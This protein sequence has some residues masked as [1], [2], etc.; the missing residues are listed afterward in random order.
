[1]SPHQFDNSPEK[2]VL[3]YRIDPYLSATSLTGATPEG[4]TFCK[5]ERKDNVATITYKKNK[6]TKEI[7]E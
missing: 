7:E 6:L 2:L 5:M 4:Y 3:A 1:M